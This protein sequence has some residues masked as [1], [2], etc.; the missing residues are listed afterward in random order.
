MIEVSSENIWYLKKRK[1]SCKNFVALFLVLFLIVG[2]FIYYN[3]VVYKEI[4]K[5]QL[6]YMNK[7]L[8]E[9]VNDAVLLSLNEDESSYSNLVSVE[10][11]NNGDIVLISANTYQVNKISRKIVDFTNAELKNKTSKGIPIPF[12]AFTGIPLISGY[13][14]SVHIKSLFVSS[15]ECEFISDFKSV[16]INQTLHSIFVEVICSSK[17]S[18]FIVKDYVKCASKVLICESVLIGKVPEIYLN[19]KLFG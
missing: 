1:K 18:G 17:L 4:S 7:N 19:N 9:S 12:L 14:N 10:K 16:G 8:T 3:F 2:L 6:D 15:V 11:N 13:G 5:Y